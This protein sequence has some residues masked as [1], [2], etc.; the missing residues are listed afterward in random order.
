MNQ[1]VFLGFPGYLVPWTRASQYRK[2]EEEDEEI[3]PWEPLYYEVGEVGGT[4]KNHSRKP[5]SPPPAPAPPPAQKSQM[6]KKK[7]KP[8]ALSLGAAPPPGQGTDSRC[9]IQLPWGDSFCWGHHINQMCL[10]AKKLLYRGFRQAT[11]KCLTYLFKVL[12]LPVLSYCSTVWDP[13]QRGRID[14]VERIQG[15]AA[16]LATGRW[17]EDRLVLC[18]ELDWCPLVTRRQYQR[19]SLCR[20]IVSGKSIIPCSVFTPECFIRNSRHAKN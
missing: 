9:I 18:S 16:R 10:K 2:L 14:Q 6:S 17:S 11:T 7:R 1:L 8:P 15:F 13:H 5:P 3:G 12:V 20:R 19:I 4:H